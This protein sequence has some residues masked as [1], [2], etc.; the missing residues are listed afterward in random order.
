[1]MSFLIS[2]TGLG[3]SYGSQTLFSNLSMA[4][5][6]GEKV[7]L[8]GPNGSGKSTVL[9]IFAGVLKPDTG[10]RLEKKFLRTV[11]LAQQDNL[12]PEKTIDDIL[13]QTLSEAAGNDSEMISR[14]RKIL[15]QA[16][17]KDTTLTV[18]QLSGGMQKRLA[19]TQA[20]VRQPDILF[21]DEPTNHLDLEGILWLEQILKD[22]P[23]AFVLVSHDRYLLN[24]VTNRTMEL[25]KAYTDGYLKVEDNYQA[26]IEKR[27]E[28]IELQLKQET[29]LANKM[30]R[31]TE[32]LRR[33]AKARTTKAQFRIDNAGKM[34]EALAE[35]KRRNRHIGD[36]DIDFQ[37]TG[38]KSKRLLEAFS[39]SKA[40]GD[41]TL[42]DNLILTLCPG[43]FI[44]LLGGNGCGKT[45]LL[46][47]LEIGRAS[48]RE[49]VS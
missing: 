9:K 7:G 13:E 42:F 34:G 15:G 11:Y 2:Y 12:D 28:Y 41:K 21:L 14:G 16:Q 33:G 48:C 31:E 47:I 38:R 36:V 17:F 25:G 10:D 1:M 6:E 24:N 5:S 26:F 37:S 32:W 44:G 30:R 3:I 22:A 8:I 49:R 23:F 39:L 4:F 45:T 19:I 40:M 46:K 43:T 29:V 20:L 35:L 27:E 18:S